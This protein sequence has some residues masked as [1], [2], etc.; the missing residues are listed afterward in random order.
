MIFVWTYFRKKEKLRKKEIK[1]RKKKIPKLRISPFD[2][3]AQ[4][5]LPLEH[6][7]STF[8]PVSTNPHPLAKKCFQKSFNLKLKKK[9]IKIFYFTLFT[10]VELPLKIKIKNNNFKKKK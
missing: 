9:E 3:N 4:S 7:F 5:S 8:E 1:I 6:I 10:N 2:K